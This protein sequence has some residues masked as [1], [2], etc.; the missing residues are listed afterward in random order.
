M[1]NMNNKLHLCVCYCHDN[2]PI[3]IVIVEMENLGS[4]NDLYL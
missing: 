4:L 3:L 1:Q 2:R